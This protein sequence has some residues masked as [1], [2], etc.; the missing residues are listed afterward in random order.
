MLP[1]NLTK[2]L[3][4]NK[5]IGAYLRVEKFIRSNQSIFV[6]LR[7]LGNDNFAQTKKGG[8][9]FRRAVLK[10]PNTWQSTS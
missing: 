5:L 4:I 10:V 1:Q 7:L 8:Y 2:L 3:Q 6:A 9:T